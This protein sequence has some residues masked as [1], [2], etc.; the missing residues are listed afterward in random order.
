MFDFGSTFVNATTKSLFFGGL[1]PLSMLCYGG[2]WSAESIAILLQRNADVMERDAKDR[3]CL[4][5]CFSSHWYNGFLDFGR[6]DWIRRY[7]EGIILLIKHGADVHAKNCWGQSVSDVAYDG[8][9]IRFLKRI[10]CIR[11]DVW[12]FSLAVCGYDISDFRPGGCR[13]AHYGAGYTRQDFEKLWEGREHL[14]PYYY[15]E[16]NTSFDDT[17]SSSDGESEESDE[18]MESEAEWV[19]D[20]GDEGSNVVDMEEDS[21]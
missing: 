12:D 2:R 6:C 18:D 5:H 21:D 8:S 20:S 4:H 11:G 9:Q 3:T 19:T 17:S 16:E 14:C 13:K 10:G 1:S 7:S 15:D